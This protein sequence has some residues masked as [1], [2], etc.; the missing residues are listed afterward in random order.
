MIS[1]PINHNPFIPGILK[2]GFGLKKALFGIS[3]QLT[4]EPEALVAVLFEDLRPL[5]C[6]QRHAVN[7][8]KAC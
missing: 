8:G 6:F 7:S 5:P 2:M 3:I 1:C 4:C